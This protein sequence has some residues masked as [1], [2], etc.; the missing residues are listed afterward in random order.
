MPVSKIVQDSIDSSQALATV[1]IKFPASQSA[2]ADANTLDDYEEGT[3][4]PRLA[5]ASSGGTSNTTNSAGWYTKIGNQV[6]IYGRIDSMVTT[7]FASSNQIWIRDLPFVSANALGVIAGSV[8]VSIVTFTGTAPTSYLGSSASAFRLYS[9][10]SGGGAALLVSAISSGNS[11]VYFV[12][13]YQ[14]A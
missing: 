10:A 11:W 6:T 4:T 3:W 2:S 13:T 5:D 9:Q 8:V 1:G 12:I 14:V 7:G